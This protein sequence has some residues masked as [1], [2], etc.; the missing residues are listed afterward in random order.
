MEIRGIIIWNTED[1]MGMNPGLIMKYKKNFI[2]AVK[3]IL[4]HFDI[5]KWKNAN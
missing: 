1:R 2:N 4:S 5:E 3:L